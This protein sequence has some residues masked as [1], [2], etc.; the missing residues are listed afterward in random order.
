LGGHSLLAIQIVSR[1]IKEF[2]LEMSVRSLF[3]SPTVAEMAVVITD[4]WGQTLDGTKMTEIL[5]EL[6]SLTDEETKRLSGEEVAK[7]PSK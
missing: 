1:V 4:S 6:E 3:R 5:T 7:I 2:E